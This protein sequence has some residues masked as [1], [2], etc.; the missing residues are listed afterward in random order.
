VQEDST[1]VNSMKLWGNVVEASSWWKRQLWMILEVVG[2][3]GVMH[4]VHTWMISSGCKPDSMWP[5]TSLGSLYTSIE[6]FAESSTVLQA[7]QASP[8]SQIW[9]A[10]AAQDDSTS[11][12]RCRTRMKTSSL[13]ICNEL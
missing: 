10:H 1:I 4:K 13:K 7:V 5:T 2:V 11:I 12:R 3:K 6:T 9:D 8:S